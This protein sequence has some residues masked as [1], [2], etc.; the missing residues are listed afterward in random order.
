MR[1]VSCRNGTNHIKNETWFICTT[2]ENYANFVTNKK[3][4]KYE[5]NLVSEH[6]NRIPC[7]NEYN[8]IQR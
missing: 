7:N 8:N 5:T 4:K 3:T 2:D 6:F 1:H